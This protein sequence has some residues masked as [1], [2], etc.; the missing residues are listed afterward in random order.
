MRDIAL[1]TKLY[2]EG[3]AR[4]GYYNR[5]AAALTEGCV[6]FIDSPQTDT[7]SGTIGDGLRNAVAI[8]TARITQHL[9]MVIHARTESVADNDLTA[10]YDVDDTIC[11][12]L[13][14]STTDIT[15]GDWLKPVNAQTYLVKA[16]NAITVDEGGAVVHDFAYARALETR[17]ADTTGL[18]KVIFF[19]HGRVV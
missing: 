9:K 6:A 3:N 1:N 2:E 18:I 11:S 8:T 5:T 10:F 13:V 19:P 15:K 12:V 4:N 14:N 17:T 7:D 16:T